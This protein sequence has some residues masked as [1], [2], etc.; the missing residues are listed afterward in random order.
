MPKRTIEFTIEMR[1]EVSS[2]EHTADI[3]QIA[4]QLKDAIYE[5]DPHHT[6]IKDVYYKLGEVHED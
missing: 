6:Y 5:S 4:E 1:E 2:S 3:E